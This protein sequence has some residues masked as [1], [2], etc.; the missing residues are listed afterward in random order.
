MHKIQFNPKDPE[1]LENPYPIYEQ[2]RSQCPVYHYQGTDYEYYVV[3]RSQDVKDVLFD[4][5]T[6][7]NVYGT[8]P[9]MQKPV[10]LG[11][12]S[13]APYHTEFRR[14]F[15]HRLSP[16]EIKRHLP[17][18]EQIVNNL[19][20]E[21]LPLGS[22]DFHDQFAYRLPVNVM[23]HLLGIPSRNYEQFNKWSSEFMKTAFV[24]DDPGAF[25]KVFKEVSAFL[26]DIVNERRTLLAKAGIKKPTEEHLGDII[27]DDLISAFIIGQVEGRYLNENEMNWG[28]VGIFTGGTDSTASTL[29]NMLWRLLEEPERWQTVCANPDLRSI[30]IEETLR[31][32]SPVHGM[33]R[34]SQ[35][36]VS[37]HGVE[38]PEK[39]KMMVGYAAANRDPEAFSDP[40]SFRLDRPLHEVRQHVAF[41]KG[42]HACPGAPVARMELTL[43]LKVLTERIPNLRL[44]GPTER[45]GA[46][47]FWGRSKLPVAWD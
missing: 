37:M 17:V 29:T 39:S 25:M 36:P 32:D 6:W 1:T 35:C 7:S 26:G 3:T 21:M 16:G 47:N 18:I 10:P 15:S 5:K 31:H 11:I 40:E 22:C 12:F 41:S 30:A 45:I 28:L 42:P 23:C 4:A 34:T 24:S 8:G 33:W 19:V 43:A 20:D 46:Y 27:P 14:V 38:I 2:L 9:H 13:D 44:A